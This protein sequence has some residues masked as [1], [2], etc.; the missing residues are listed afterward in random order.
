MSLLDLN[1][2]FDKGDEDISDENL[3]KVYAQFVEDFISNPF[4]LNG[5]DVYLEKG[6]AKPKAYSM[7]N[8]TFWHLITR[9]SDAYDGE[10]IFISQR[11]NR[12]HWIKHILCNY[13]D[14]L[15][16]YYKWRDD[17]GICKDHYWLHAKEYMVVVH[18]KNTGFK[19]VTGFCVD[20]EEISTFYG[21]F[22]EYRDGE[23]DCK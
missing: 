11:A 14:P 4:Q 1:P 23:S 7:Y 13:K 8:K 16:R 20:R 19:I 15:I 12:V 22:A 6:N 17:D 9:K 2:F 10:R 21:R 18:E 3:Q 5:K